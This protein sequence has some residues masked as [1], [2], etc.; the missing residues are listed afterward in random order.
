MFN[1]SFQPLNWICTH[2]ILACLFVGRAFAES[3]PLPS[4]N[5]G[6]AKNSILKFIE[7]TTNEV[8]SNF[9]PLEDR[10]VTFDQDGTLWVEKPLY[11]QWYFTQDRL[12]T[13]T[14]FHPFTEIEKLLKR[15]KNIV[16]MAFDTLTLQDIAQILATTNAGSTVEE[17]HQI[18]SDWLKDSEHPFYH[19][20]FTEL[21]YQPML[22]VIQ[23]FQKN[24][25]KTYIVSGGSQEFIRV[26]SEEIYNIPTS[27]IIG[28]VVKVK[29]ETRNGYPVLVREPEVL[30]VNDH[31]GKPEG[32]NLVIGKRPVAAFGNSDGDKE[33]LEFA[34]SRKGARLAL[35]VHHDDSSRE[36]AYD[37]HSFVGELSKELMK[38]AN[39]SGW[40]VVSMKNDWKVIFP[41]EK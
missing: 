24:G 3:D 30:F 6:A 37:D 13:L 39:E 16:Q 2:T 17:Y 28:S 8:N 15:L 35:L 19:R 32:I 26:Y 18:V 31:G 1:R 27:Q 23:L 9:I 29:Y 12:T 36:Y 11:S 5:E 34:W 7:I 22:E 10:I 14:P 40:T 33:M 20:P 41:W 21:V 4:W 38:E 25:F